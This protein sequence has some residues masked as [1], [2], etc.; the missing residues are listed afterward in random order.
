MLNSVKTKII[1][2]VTILFLLGVTLMTT[3]SSLQVKKKTEESLINHSTLMVDGMGSS[4]VNFLG[5]YEKGLLQMTNAPTITDFVTEDATTNKEMANQA[6]AIAKS[7]FGDFLDIY[8]DVSAIYFSTK[9]NYSVMLPYFELEDSYDARTR[10]WYENAVANPDIANTTSPYIDN[11]TGEFVITM[12]KA[13]QKNGEIVGVV[14]IDIFLTTLTD[15]LTKSELGYEGYPIILD[16]EGVAIVHPT[17]NGKSMMNE[18]FVK[19]MFENG[20][21]KGAIHYNDGDGKVAVFTTIPELNWKISAIYDNK[22]INKTVDDLRRSMITIALMTLVLFFIVLYIMISRMIKPLGQLKVLMGSVSDGDLTVRSEINSKDEIGALGDSFN[23]MIENMN[24]IITVVNGSA[25]NVR[26]SSESLSAV[27]E[28][29]S[30]SSEEVAH[31]VNEIAHGASRSAEDAE[32][33]TERA[34]LL[35]EQINEIT[36]KAAVMTDIATKAGEMNTNGQGQ[37]A[38]LNKSFLTWE[39]NLQSMAQVIGT[40]EGK[41]GAIGSVMETITVIS[42]QTNLLALNASIEAARAGEHGKGF[43][44]VAN[45]V[46]KLAEQSARATEEVKVTIQELQTESRLVT[47]Q[48]YETRENFKNQGS[49]VHDTEVTF[50]E[51]STLMA[52]MQDSIDSVYEEIKKVDAH[53]DDVADTIQ[54]MAATS[55][56]TAAACQEV[57]ASTE[58]Q[59][60]AIRS[61]SSAAETLTE[62]SEE[63]SNAVNRFKV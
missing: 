31:A 27:A 41:V 24:S 37:M 54:T 56:E 62:L 11:G 8:E 36:V 13:I 63:L 22:V 3:L 38:Q 17:E 39:S 2:T 26:I 10:P 45:E 42:A 59:L 12:S 61:V 18:P 43:A 30:A 55:E 33:V 50:N 46:R 20:T 4:I 6:L 40:L 34:N 44:V 15:S 58:E 9:D 19:D 28:E 16:S 29:T 23:G 49:V 53:K 48:M 32:I 51:I 1:L 14:G 35:G 21:N 47:T 5:Q 60:R 57:S 25:S 52:D 7:E